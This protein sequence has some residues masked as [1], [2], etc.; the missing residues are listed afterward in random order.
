MTNWND[1]DYCPECHAGEGRPCHSQSRT[2]PDEMY[3]M[4]KA[5]KRRPLRP[6]VAKGLANLLAGAALANDLEKLAD[7]ELADLL[8][9][10]VLADVRAP[11][12]V[13]ELVTEVARRLR[14]P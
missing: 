5:H 3:R 14:Q 8:I 12:P 11:D 9:E 2:H 6:E 4:D 10:H 7:A 1:Y 13:F